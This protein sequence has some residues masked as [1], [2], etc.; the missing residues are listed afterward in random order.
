MRGDRRQRLTVENLAVGVSGFSQPQDRILK[1]ATGPHRVEH[2]RELVLDDVERFLLVRQHQHIPAGQDRLEDNGDNCVALA[3]PGRPLDREKPA[4]L[5]AQCRQN[6]ALLLVQR[7]RRR[8]HQPAVDRR[9]APL[10]LDRLLQ[11]RRLFRQ[12]RQHDLAEIQ[13]DRL[14]RPQ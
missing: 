3:A 6:L 11:A 10:L 5:L 14:A 13:C 1:V 9:I 2:F 12:K 8:E 7:H 4:L